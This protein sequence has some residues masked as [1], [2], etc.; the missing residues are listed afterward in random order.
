MKR[1][2]SYFTAGLFT[3]ASAAYADP[4]V[5]RITGSTAFR[6]ATV[7][8]ISK[9]FDNNTF[10]A[11]YTGTSFTGARAANFHGLVDGNEVLI[12]TSWSGAEGGVQ[13]VA[14]GAAPLTVKFL[15]DAA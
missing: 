1:T 2:L 5:I 8:A 15:P 10:S 11:G 14:F 4:T 12:K 6:S 7:T 9:I 3:L 13:T